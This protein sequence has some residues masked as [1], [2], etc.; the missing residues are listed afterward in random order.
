MSDASTAPK[1]VRPETG[2]TERSEGAFAARTERRSAK[3]ASGACAGFTLDNDPTGAQFAAALARVFVMAR[4]D[5]E[6]GARSQRARSGAWLAEWLGLESWRP[7][8]E[9]A[10][11]RA[12]RDARS[13][14]R[15][16]GHPHPLDNVHERALN[17]HV[18][19][20]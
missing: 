14:L 16:E 15:V 2:S 9:G 4:W 20:L 5:V 8:H 7:W 12:Y 10:L 3:P 19:A 13:H 17:P 11:K 6:R 18:S 1:D